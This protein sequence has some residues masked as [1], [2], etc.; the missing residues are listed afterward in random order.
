MS[1]KVN[2]IPEG[3]HTMTPYLMAPDGHAAVRFYQQAF[4][5][6]VRNLETDSAGK[7][8]NAELQIG[9]SMLMLGEHEVSAGEP[10]KLP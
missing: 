2:P 7:L 3:F 4:G 10:G 1:N 5:A 8:L 6:V 9:D